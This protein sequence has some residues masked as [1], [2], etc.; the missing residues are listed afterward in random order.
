MNYISTTQL[1]SE[2]SK[3]VNLLARG[4]SAFLIFRSKVIATIS[5]YSEKAIKTKTGKNLSNYISSIA[6]KMSVAPKDRKKKYN[7]HLRSKYLS[8]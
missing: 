1:R 2:S 8:K 4:D 5:P 7:A 6:P 3:L